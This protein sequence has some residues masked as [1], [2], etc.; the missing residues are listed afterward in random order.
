MFP[1]PSPPVWLPLAIDDPP[2]ISVLSDAFQHK[3]PFGPTTSKKKT[4]LNVQHQVSEAARCRNTHTHTH[5]DTRDT[6]NL[7]ADFVHK[8]AYVCIN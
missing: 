2:F 1:R 6:S 8:F 5:T 7:E 3:L 4:R